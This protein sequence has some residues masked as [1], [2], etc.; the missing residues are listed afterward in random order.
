M[1]PDLG[2]RN[3]QASLTSDLVDPTRCRANRLSALINYFCTHSQSP[4]TRSKPLLATDAGHCP[5]WLDKIDV[6][7]MVPFFLLLD[8]GEDKIDQFATG[9]ARPQKLLDIVLGG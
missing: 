2:K 3:P 9:S 4:S 8:G 1:L 6:I 7:D 5:Q